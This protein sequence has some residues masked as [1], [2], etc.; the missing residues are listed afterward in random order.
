MIAFHTHLIIHN[1]TISF[2]TEK[3]YFLFF[4]IVGIIVYSILVREQREITGFHFLDN[5]HFPI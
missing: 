1:N 4:L 5:L 2:Y 3:M